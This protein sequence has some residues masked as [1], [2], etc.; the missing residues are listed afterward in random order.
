MAGCYECTLSPCRLGTWPPASCPLRG[1]FG[2]REMCDGFQQRLEV[3][4]G[5]ATGRGVGVERW[6]LKSLRLRG[7]LQVVE[8]YAR[9]NVATVSSHHLARSVGVRAS[10]VRRDLSGLGHFGTPGRGYSVSAVGTALREGLRVSA[11]RPTVW[12]GAAR[13]AESENVKQALEMV[14]CIL[15]GVFDDGQTGRSVRGMPVQPLAEAGALAEANSAAVAVLASEAAAQPEIV[16][17]LAEAGVQAVLNLTSARLDASAKVVVEQA[18]LGSQLLR[19]L[20]RLGEPGRSDG[21]EVDR[22]DDDSI[23]RR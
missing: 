16:R 18:D 21:R 6:E 20:S 15:V 11:P 7:Y 23:A 17:A 19:L 14:N 12:L 1:R 4:K 5:V 2:G 8:D 10:L 22:A 13:L 9:R 3:T